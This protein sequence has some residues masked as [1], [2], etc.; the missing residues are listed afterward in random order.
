MT[1]AD[2]HLYQRPYIPISIRDLYFYFSSSSYLDLHFLSPCSSPFIRS[3]FSRTMTE[4]KRRWLYSERQSSTRDICD[5]K[6]CST[7]TWFVFFFLSLSRSSFAPVLVYPLLFLPT[8]WRW[9]CTSD[10]RMQ[11]AEVFLSLSLSSCVY[12]EKKCLSAFTRT[13]K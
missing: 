4:R 9:F 12:L 1:L 11:Y 2:L 13:N 10:I 7:H 8:P 3:H 6:I 5:E